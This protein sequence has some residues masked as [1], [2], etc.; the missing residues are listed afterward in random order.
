M[1]F[2][3]KSVNLQAEQVYQRIMNSTFALDAAILCVHSMPQPLSDRRLSKR[4][5]IPSKGNASCT[6]MH[7]SHGRLL[8]TNN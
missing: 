1:Y 2:K 7:I 3:E 4:R 6:K 8:T 5:H